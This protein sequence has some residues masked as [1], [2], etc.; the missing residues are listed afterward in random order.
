MAATGARNLLGATHSARRAR[1]NKVFRIMNHRIIAS[2][3][4][5]VLALCACTTTGGPANPIEA[6]WVGQSAGK[7]FALHS[8][9][10]SDASAGANTVYSWRG[11]YRKIKTQDGR[12]ANVSCSAQITVDRDY[13]IRNI[14]ITSDRPGARGASYCAE[15]LAGD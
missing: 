13:V 10:V 11:G 8:P 1:R 4:V 7:F 14:R 6:R 15:L 5:F 9:P 3:A 2:S 12:M